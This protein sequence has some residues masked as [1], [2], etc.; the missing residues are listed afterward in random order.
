MP[1][2]KIADVVWEIFPQQSGTCDLLRDY[3]T[4]E[5][6]A[7]EIVPENM[8][9]Q[10]LEHIQLLQYINERLAGKYHGLMLHA[11]AIVYRGK[12]YLFVALPGTG[13]TTHIS[14]WR[15]VVGEEVLVL[16]GDK[17]FLRNQDGKILVYGGPWRGKEGFGC[18]GVYPLGGVYLLNRGQENRVCQAS[19][20]EKLGKLLDAILLC[21]DHGA[22][23]NVMATLDALCKSVPVCML[24]CN[25]ET[26]AVDVVRK[27]IEEGD[28][29]EN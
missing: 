19:S 12:A 18:N 15:K 5:L 11:A 10:E 27:H 6:V 25:M 3:E 20:Q 7:H 23:L 26:D 21:E 2:Y 8:K 24:Y 22:M 17:P 28:A 13:K 16:N 9:G 14:L 29:Y 4:T 1:N